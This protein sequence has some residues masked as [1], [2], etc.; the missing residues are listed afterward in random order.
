MR[1]ALLFLIIFGSVPFILKRPWI[2]VL[3]WCWLAYMNPHRLAWSAA[4]D[5]PFSMLI[6]VATIAAFV[7][8]GGKRYPFTAV[9]GLMI[10]YALWTGVTT[11]FALM[12]A[13]AL[14]K[15]EMFMKV[16]VMNIITICLINTRERL[17]ALIWVITLSIGFFALKGGLFTILTGGEHRVWGPAESTIADNNHLAL[18]LIMMLP[19]MYYLSQI[20][21]K[22][23]IRFGM[24][25]LMVLT[26]FAIVATYSRGALVAIATMCF[27]MWVKSRRRALL[28][29]GGIACVITLSLFM[30]A[31]WYERMYSIGQYEEDA[32]AGGRFDSWNFGIRLANARPLGGGFNVFGYQHI[33]NVYYPDSVHGLARAAHSVY[34]EVL[35]EHGWIGF[36]IYVS[37]GVAAFFSCRWVN[38][39]TR[40]RPDL[41]SLNDMSR[42]VQVSLVGFAAGGAF[43][44]V[45]HYDLYWH[46]IAI[47]VILRVLTEQALR[48]PASQ[49]AAA[50]PIPVA[51]PMRPL[52]AAEVAAVPQGA[53]LGGQSGFLIE[54][55]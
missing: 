23:Y 1:D 17:Q 26:L 20:A 7:L 25:G 29:F 43:I 41:T 45:A 32:S 53:R 30:P 55:S 6:G 14:E 2:G 49:T 33:F 47:I 15:W 3:V 12:P 36:F 39:R 31:Q 16:M 5:F 8:H 21:Q 22:K 40:D 51:M 10:V 46:I 54:R 50:G 35:G 27:F 44:N 52:G 34:F 13:S 42:M 24:L 28:F 18:A 4:Y 11:I 37:L 9:S 38:L 19:F 48:Q